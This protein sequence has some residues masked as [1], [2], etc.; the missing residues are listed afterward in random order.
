M[1]R[2]RKL[3]PR[4]RR[5]I[6]RGLVLLGVLVLLLV[7]HGL[8]GKDLRMWWLLQDLETEPAATQKAIKGLGWTYR[9]S[10]RRSLLAGGRSFAAQLRLTEIALAEPYY[11]KDAVNRALESDRPEVGRAAAVAVLK[12][13]ITVPPGPVPDAVLRVFRDWCG[14]PSARDLHAGLNHLGGYRDPRLIDV[15]L[16]LVRAGP[17]EG[18]DSPAQY[19]RA[20]TN[21]RITARVLRIYLD[22]PG[23]VEALKEVA[24]REED[25]ELVQ[26][27]VMQALLHDG[28]NVDRK[29]ALK[30]ARSGNVYVRQ[31]IANNLERVREAWVGEVLVIL[32]EDENEVVRRG[33]LEGLTK[34]RDPLVM[35]ELHYLAEDSFG[36]IKGD[37]AFA[38]GRYRRVDLIPFL[39]WCLEDPDP[40][41]VEKTL[42]SLARM[43]GEHHGFSEQEWGQFKVGQPIMPGPAGLARSKMIKAFMNSDQRKRTA[44][45]IW[46]EKHPPRYT[47]ADRVPHLIRQLRHKDSRNVQKAMRTLVRITRRDVG[48]PAEVIDLRAPE[49]ER[50]SALHRFIENDRDRVAAEW[51][52]WHREREE[53]GD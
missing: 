49:G 5:W 45:A 6:R 27:S 40:L 9:S 32:L 23:V 34:R 46:S 39:V 20:V 11:L 25:I 28:K 52:S 35:K 26:V 50:S 14:T 41:V 8:F 51:E 37:V 38:V 31:V 44:L 19:K 18:V 4:L 17:E 21:R 29:M 53:S 2:K 48:F 10:L 36:F 3:S 43:T 42:V 24:E 13:G 22:V 12:N 16:P 1:V 33:A 7:A 15:L 30:A 47:D